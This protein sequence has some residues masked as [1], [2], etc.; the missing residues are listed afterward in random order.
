MNQGGIM[1]TDMGILSEI[2]YSD[3]GGSFIQNHY[4]NDLS[5]TSNEA[6]TRTLNNAYKIIDYTS[7]DTDMQALLLEKTIVMAIQQASM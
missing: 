4:E 7:T 5:L 1:L 2:T 3:Y 6:D